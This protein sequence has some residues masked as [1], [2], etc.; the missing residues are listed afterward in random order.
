M[1][2]LVAAG[3]GGPIAFVAGAGN[4][5]TTTGLRSASVGLA[6][7]GT[8]TASRSPA[9][10]TGTATCG[11]WYFPNPTAGIGSSFWVKLTI[12]TQTFTTIS[13]NA[14]GTVLSL[15]TAVSWTFTNSA[16]STEGT[17]TGTFAIYTDAAGTNQVATGTLT[18]DVG[19]AP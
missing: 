15:G 13:G 17:G 4:L 18:W 5:L 1:Q 3:A 16:T 19:F 10:G 12:N 14:T 6:S 7:D 9:G 11:P 2:M 8:G